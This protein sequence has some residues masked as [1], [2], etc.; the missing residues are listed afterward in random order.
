MGI[1]IPMADAERVEVLQSRSH[2]GGNL[3]QE[4]ELEAGAVSPPAPQKRLRARQMKLGMQIAVTPER[5][6]ANWPATCLPYPHV[7]ATRAGAMQHR[8]TRLDH[9]HYRLVWAS[10]Y[11]H[12]Q[13]CKPQA[14]SSSASMPWMRQQALLHHCCRDLESRPSC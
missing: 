5:Y 7:V 10:F 4:A 14:G 11:H 1:H 13:N 3:Q 6:V 2:A 8:F 12:W 9:S